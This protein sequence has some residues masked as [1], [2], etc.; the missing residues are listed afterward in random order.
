MTRL[1]YLWG[2]LRCVVG[3][4]DWRNDGLIVYVTGYHGSERLV[5]RCERDDCWRVRFL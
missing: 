4:H 3:R 1:R 5:Q 2:W